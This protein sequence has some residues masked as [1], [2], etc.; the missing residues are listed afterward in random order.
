MRTAA[1]NLRPLDSHE[2]VAV[3]EVIGDTA[4]AGLATAWG[5]WSGRAAEVPAIAAAMTSLRGSAAWREEPRAALL[6]A[7]EAAAR[8]LDALPVD[9]DGLG[10]PVAW[11]GCAIVNRA[12]IHVAW[13]GGVAAFLYVEEALVARTSPDTEFDR[14]LARGASRAALEASPVPLRA[15]VLDRVTPARDGQSSPRYERWPRPRGR[16]SLLLA[17]HRLYGELP[18]PA[19]TREDGLRG[20]LLDA[21]D[22]DRVAAL[23]EA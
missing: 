3:A 9:D 14:L 23:I 16:W 13:V 22:D 12:G 6:G 4:I 5:S 21:Q 8:A 2:E 17:P 11:L 1:L 15:I 18:P 19:P 7:C 10:P 20:L